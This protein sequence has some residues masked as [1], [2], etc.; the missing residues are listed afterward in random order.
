MSPDMGELPMPRIITEQERNEIVA[1]ECALNTW[2][3]TRNSYNPNEL[4]EYIHPPTND[5]RSAIEVFE[6]CRNKPERY[7]LY[8]NADKHVATTWTGKF[9]G[10]VTFGKAWRD[11]FGGMRVSVRIR[12]INGCQYTGTYFKTAGDYARVRRVKS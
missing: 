12:A 5:E 2:R 1:R 9:L 7:F 6:F 3:G 11:N 10:D 8:I 4:P